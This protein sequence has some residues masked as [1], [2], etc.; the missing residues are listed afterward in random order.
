MTYSTCYNLMNGSIFHGEGYVFAITSGDVV[1]SFASPTLGIKIDA[2]PRKDN[3]VFCSPI[4]PGLFFENCSK[5]CGVNH[6]VMPI[7]IVM[8]RYV[9]RG[10]TSELWSLFSYSVDFLK[11][12]LMKALKCVEISLIVNQ[13]LYTVPDTPF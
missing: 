9:P 1:H 6:S 5:I 11:D 13:T 12:S 7:G 3:S 8:D 4:I 2:V 10:N